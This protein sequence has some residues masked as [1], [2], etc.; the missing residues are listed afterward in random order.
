MMT[1]LLG[2]TIGDKTVLTAATTFR[3]EP[4]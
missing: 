2:R 4:Y 1:Q 3:S